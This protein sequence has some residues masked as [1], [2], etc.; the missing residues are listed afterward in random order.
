M[1]EETATGRRREMDVGD[2]SGREN[3]PAS[4]AAT[5]AQAGTQAASETA[6]DVAQTAKEEARNVA[7]EVST[8]A[9]RVADDVRWQVR[10][11]A[12]QGHGTM[13]NQLRRTADELRDMSSGRDDSPARTLVAN[14]A[15]RTSRF[16]EQLESR[17]PDGVLAEVKE[18][19][20]RRPGTFLIAAA[21]AGFVMGRVGK[22]VFSAP[23]G[24]LS[25]G[26]GR[27]TGSQ[28]DV[29]RDDG[30]WSDPKPTAVATAPAYETG[31]TTA[32]AP[33]YETGKVTATAPVY[34]TG[35]ATAYGAGAE[36]AVRPDEPVPANPT[37]GS[38]TSA[39]PSPAGPQGSRL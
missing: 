22:S 4:T 17:G 14:L 7:S 35:A 25:P 24:P 9:R 32:T 3:G 39:S 1:Y 26:D 29:I 27:V 21:A 10:D 23:N 2:R 31:T 18:F 20:R 38:P 11:K 15:E 8:Q 5:A 16:A 36:P 13:V 12:Q 6:R 37:P 33:A 30:D 34:E 28:A 19:A